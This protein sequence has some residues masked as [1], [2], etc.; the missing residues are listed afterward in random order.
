MSTTFRPRSRIDSPLTSAR[1]TGEMAGIESSR[2][3][4]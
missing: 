4:A 3:A 1:A 2:T